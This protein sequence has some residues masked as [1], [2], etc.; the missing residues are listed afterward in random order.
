MIS[1]KGISVYRVWLLLGMFMV[2]LIYHNLDAGRLIQYLPV[3]YAISILFF[4]LFIMTFKDTFAYL[5]APSSIMILY[6][7]IT[8]SLGALWLNNGWYA[9]HRQDYA[10]YARLPFFQL[11]NTFFLLCLPVT[12]LALVATSRSLVSEKELPVSSTNMKMSVRSTTRFLI[13]FAIIGFFVAARIRISIPW[14]T[15]SDLS[16]LMELAGAFT[17]M[18]F[19]IRARSPYRYPALLLFFVFFAI[20]EFDNKRIA[21]FFL[22]TCIMQESLLLK[23]RRWQLRHMLWGIV[24]LGILLS[25]IMAM[26]ILRGYGSFDITSPIAAFRAIPLYIQSDNFLFAFEENLELISSYFHNVKAVNHALYT[27]DYAYG[28]TI[29][30]GLTVVVPRSIWPNKPQSV[31]ELYTAI[32]YPALAAKGG[33]YVPNLYAEMLWNFGVT[34][35][36]FGVF[37]IFNFFNYIYFVMV[38]YLREKERRLRVTFSLIFLIG[39]YCF[40]IM[41]FRGSGWD[42][43]AV[44]VIVFAATLSGFFAAAKIICNLRSGRKMLS[45]THHS[46]PSNAVSKSI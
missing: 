25:G 33:T 38:R 39:W 2:P 18:A 32:Y 5:F 45:R 44:N 16:F 43:L 37:V 27:H 40:Q 21:I 24:I 30:A 9:L 11:G 26:S 13:F 35:G 20:S 1:R 8:F 28:A 6:V 46:F 3:Y 23:A 7:G 22:I 10:T 4:C 29:L 17:V 42:L 14:Y 36:L 34:G 41:L 15:N 19:L 12:L 31:I